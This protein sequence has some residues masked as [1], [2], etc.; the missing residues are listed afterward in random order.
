MQAEQLGCNGGHD[1]V[2]QRNGKMSEEGK[3]M[4]QQQ[5]E[6]EEVQP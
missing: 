4:E 3:D 1:Q 6:G 2:E 5:Q